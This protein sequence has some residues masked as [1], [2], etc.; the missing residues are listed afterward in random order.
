MVFV[1]MGVQ[2]TNAQNTHYY[3]LTRK[4]E[5][6]VSSTDVSGGQF[7]TFIGDICYESDKKGKNVGNGTMT[8]NS[9]YSTSQYKIYQGSCY[10][11]SNASFKF[12]S[13]KSV[14]NIVCDNGNVYVYKRCTAPTGQ[15]TCSLVRN[16]SSGG[17]NGG[18]YTGGFIPQPV[19]PTPTPTPQTIP[20]SPTTAP[21]TQ[22]SQI[23]CSYC[24]GTGRVAKNTYPP[25]YGATDYKVRCPECGE[26][27]LKS[28]G[29][30]HVTCPNCH[31]RGYIE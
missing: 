13:D 19:Y 31:G 22:S 2:I 6:N 28:A 14:L 24:H 17:G 4:V 27:H 1:I 16:S 15:E 9:A 8:R 25:M 7:F 23:K 5:N 30:V 26:E 18:I 20:S 10:Y 11:G 3:K 29:H 12:N 21:T